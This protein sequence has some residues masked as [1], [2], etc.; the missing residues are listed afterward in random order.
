MKGNSN[1]AAI[2]PIFERDGPTPREFKAGFINRS[3]S[4]V[5]S[6]FF[7][8]ARPF[9]CGRAP[10]KSGNA[11]G[12]VDASG[13]LAIPAVADVPVRIS[14]D[15]VIY[16]R[17]GKRGIM[18]LEGKVVVEPRYR[19]LVEFQEG[20]S[21]MSAND[22][23]GFVGTDGQPIAPAIYEDARSF[24]A[25][26]APV[27][28]GG[29]WGYINKSLEF[30]IPPQFDFALPF[31]EGLA[32]VQQAGL[33]GYIDR[34]G[35]PAIFPRF[36]NARDFHEGLAEIMIGNH[37][38]YIDQGGAEVI[39]PTFRRTSEFV[40]GLAAVSPNDDPKSGY[41]FINKEGRFV[42]P[43]QYEIVSVFR[44]GLCFVELAEEVGY[45]D[46]QGEIVWR[47][48]YVDAGRIS[49]L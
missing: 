32:R 49:E 31:S 24:S 11:W 34:A 16:T 2:F 14:E 29:K 6:C 21:W 47:G 36:E 1:N 8:N 39:A 19:I 25:G 30:D 3:G 43:R 40:E 15:R 23:Y 35:R 5:L 38:G 22:L 7:D 27:K 41:G 33:W 10:V 9:H 26:L 17:N 48:A 42:I 46:H 45:I 18:T 20:A 4:I 37:W 12:A 44:H 28:F 13:R